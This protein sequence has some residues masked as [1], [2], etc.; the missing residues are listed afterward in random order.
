MK[1][2]VLLEG[3]VSTD[4][5][6]ASL[7]SLGEESIFVTARVSVPGK[8]VVLFRNEEEVPVDLER[9]VLRVVASTFA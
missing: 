3:A 1:A 9:G 7:S 2:F 5:V 6:A 4:V 8:A